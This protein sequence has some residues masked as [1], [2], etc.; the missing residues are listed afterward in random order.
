MESYKA[1]SESRS[2]VILVF[3][4][5]EAWTELVLLYGDAYFDAHTQCMLTLRMRMRDFG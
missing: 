4:C 1:Q 2:E 3:Y 5:F